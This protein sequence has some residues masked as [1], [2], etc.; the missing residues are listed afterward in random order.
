[1]NEDLSWYRDALIEMTGIIP[2]EEEV[3]EF[4][5]DFENNLKC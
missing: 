1:M 3:E 5:K 4:A 2:S